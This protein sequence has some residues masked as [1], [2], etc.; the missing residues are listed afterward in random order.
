M[1]CFIAIDAGFKKLEPL[2]ERLSK[3]GGVKAVQPENLHIT[4]KFLGEISESRVEDVKNVMKKALSDFKSFTYTARGVGAFPSENYIRVVFAGVEGGEVIVDMQRKLENELE[5]IGFKR[6]KRDFVPH[7]TL[8][9]VKIPRRKAQL[10]RF[11]Q[12]FKKESFGE[13]K[14]KEVYLM[15]SILKPSGPEYRPIFTLQLQHTS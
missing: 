6:E 4:L 11:I 1:R 3:I 8:A 10:Q 5:K 13:L 7:I 9:R 12:E 14:V 2:I 15:Q